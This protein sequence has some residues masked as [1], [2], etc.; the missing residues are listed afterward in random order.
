MK[1]LGIGH[2]LGMT[3]VALLLPGVAAAQSSSAP[4]TSGVFGGTASHFIPRDIWNRMLERP[5]DAGDGGFLVEAPIDA[6]WTALSEVLKE[7]DVPISFSDRA[8]GE[9]GTIKAKMY[10]RLGRAAVSEFLRCGE[11]TSGPNA[12]M[13]VVYVSVAA[14]VKP[15]TGNQ[16]AAMAMIGGEAV[17]L[18]NGRNDVVPCTSSGRFELKVATAVRKRLGLK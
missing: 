3:I 14:F 4:T 7:F 10:K 17:D 8:A 2:W 16:T 1:R 11:G 9:M 6:V 15:G 12:D 5:E 18:P 13:Y